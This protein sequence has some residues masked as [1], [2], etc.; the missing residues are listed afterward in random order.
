MHGSDL[1]AERTHL[2]RTQ[3]DLAAAL[4]GRWNRQAIGRW[5]KGEVPPAEVPAVERVLAE[6]RESP[7]ERPTRAG[8]PGEAIHAA[9]VALGLTQAD[10]AAR[11]T[12]TGRSVASATVAGWEQGYAPERRTAALLTAL[13]PRLTYELE[14]RDNPSIGSFDQWERDR[15]AAE[16]IAGY[17]TI[18]EAEQA[19]EQRAARGDDTATLRF[20]ASALGGTPREGVL[21]AEATEAELLKELAR[22]LARPVEGE[23]EGEHAPQG[24]A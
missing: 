20:I 18:R 3:S 15:L 14:A 21:L 10:L 1:A 16:Q 17:E 24:R 7:V 2:G 6:W 22:R 8:I 19:A 13:G 5:E 9:R 4:G 12:A 23:H 11:I